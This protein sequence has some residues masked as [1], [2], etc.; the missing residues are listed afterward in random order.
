MIPLKGSLFSLKM[1]VGSKRHDY[2]ASYV[3]SVNQMLAVHCGEALKRAFSRWTLGYSHARFNIYNT[4][5]WYHLWRCFPMHQSSYNNSS[6]VPKKQLQ[7]NRT[8]WIVAP[9]KTH[10]APNYAYVPWFPIPKS[11]LILHIFDNITPI[12]SWNC[13]WKLFAH[14]FDTTLEPIPSWA[15]P[16]SLR[17]CCASSS[18]HPSPFDL[19][20]E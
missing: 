8:V 11:N 14:I 18:I 3:V 19:G 6:W 17:V 5:S 20:V 4:L 7:L 16:S 1:H 13:I 2:K 9:F 10:K 12:F 15:E